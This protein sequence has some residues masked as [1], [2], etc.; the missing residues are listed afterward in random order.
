M[1]PV[2][3]RARFPD[4]AILILKLSGIERVARFHAAGFKALAQPAHALLR[5]AMREGIRHD[6]SA[7]LLLQRV[8]ADRGG[9]G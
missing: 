4:A 8:V 6:M 9:S 7:R 2:A 5:S 3:R 1:K